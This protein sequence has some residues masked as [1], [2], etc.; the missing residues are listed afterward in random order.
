MR[1]VISIH[2]GQAGVQTGT[3]CWELFSSE[4]G[5]T[6]T[7]KMQDTDGL[8][9]GTQN[10]SQDSFSDGFHT[11]FEEMSK[12]NYTPRALFVDLE[13]SVIDMVR[14]GPYKDMYCSKQ[15]IN[16][17]EDAANNYGRGYCTVG[18]AILGRVMNQSRKMI[19]TCD[20]L[21]GFIIYH[22]FGGGT[23]SGFHALLSDNIN[24]EYPKSSKMEMSIFPS[25]MLATAVVEPY[26][27]ALT[28]NATL[29][30]SDCVFLADNEAM[31]NICQNR[32]DIDSPTYR[33]LNNILAQ[34]VSSI[35]AS[36]RFKSSLN[37]DFIDFQTNLVPY[38]RIHFPIFSYAP[39]VPSTRVTHESLTA[40]DL[41]LQ[42][43]DPTN[44]L[45][46]CPTDTSR[47]IACCL[48]YRG[49]ITPKDV[50]FAIAMLKAKK[51]IRFVTWSP[52]GF[53]IGINSRTPGVIPNSNMASMEKSVCMVY[54]TTAMKEAW[55]A[56]NIKFSLMLKKRAFLHW[57]TGEGMEEDDFLATQENLALLEADYIQLELE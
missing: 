28:T 11:F 8:P 27:A 53:K 6:P 35:T 45:A 44:R 9:E 36:L 33:N 29:E 23:G 42:C 26:N 48:L 13:P 19:E 5:L 16:D 24:L 37:A 55:V 14:N 47:Y 7:G 56:L 38:P 52:T 41:T 20:R 57:Y 39:I 34:T 30:F 43:F 4:H 46:K 49:D 22:S 31:Y 54:N 1:E 21:Q 18:K 2:L 17:K 12:G 40:S 32:L 15:M 50:N 25:P 51:N 10:V 3:T